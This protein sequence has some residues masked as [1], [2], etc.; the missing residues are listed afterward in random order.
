MET[1]GFEPAAPLPSVLSRLLYNDVFNEIKCVYSRHCHINRIPDFALAWSQTNPESSSNKSHHLLLH[2]SFLLPNCSN[3]IVSSLSD[4][5]GFWREHRNRGKRRQLMS[6][7][8]KAAVVHAI[9]INTEAVCMTIAIACT[10][11]AFVEQ[12][13]R[14]THWRHTHRGSGYDDSVYNGS[15]QHK[16]RGY[17]CSMKASIVQ[18]V[19]IHKTAVCMMAV[20]HCTRWTT[21]ANVD[22]RGLFQAIVA[23]SFASFSRLPL[24]APLS[25]LSF[26]SF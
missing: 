24:L 12:N 13:C 22:R 1:T 9:I 3:R 4:E 18:A 14:R 6:A 10:T 11:A 5:R 16:Q 23:P 26:C 17:L 25:P 20:N 15:V 2:P 7:I 8:M 21:E 19:I